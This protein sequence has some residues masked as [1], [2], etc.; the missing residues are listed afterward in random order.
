MDIAVVGAG[1]SVILNQDM[2][3]IQSARIA[4]AAVAP[5]PLLVG[6][7]SQYLAGREISPETIHQ[8]AELARKA[9]TPIKDMRGTVDQRGHLAGV[10]TRRAIEKAIERARTNQNSPS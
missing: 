8:A 9:A 4:L 7:A 1:A 5:R 10:L 6:S 2:Q 3:T